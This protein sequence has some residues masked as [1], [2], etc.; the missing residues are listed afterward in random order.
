MKTKILLNGVGRIG[1]A[2][3]KIILENKNFEIIAINE[4]N[5]YL[6]NIV[7]SINHDSTYGN[8]SDKFKVIQNNFIENSNNKIKVLNHK[9][10]N[11]IDLSNIDII[12]DA[13]GVKEDIIHKIFDPYF[14][15][16]YNNQGTG[17]GL[18]MSAKIIHEHFLGQIIVKNENIEF[19]NKTYKGAK[20][21]I[22]LQL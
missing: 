4:I 9:N 6:E 5:P 17:I 1:K 15:T 3:L 12:I 21:F 19:N 18:Y 20:F 16:K 22:I 14:T 10:L 2:I 8:I 11:E 13:S 7:Y